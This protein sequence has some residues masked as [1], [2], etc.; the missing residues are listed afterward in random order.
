MVHRLVLGGG[1]A[2]AREEANALIARHREFRFTRFRGPCSAYVVDTVRTV[3]GCYFLTDTVRSCITQ[4]VNM[5][6]DADSAGALAG[7]L[8]GA[9]YGATTIPRAWVN[10]LDPA[11]ATEIRAQTT[12]LLALAAKR[13]GSSA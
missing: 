3:L 1:V 12:A 5:G 10:R 7:M 9:T 13:S 2:S 4:T 8:A 6:G 11:V